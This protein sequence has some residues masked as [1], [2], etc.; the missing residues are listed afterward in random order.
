MKRVE[1][2]RQINF[3]TIGMNID[4]NFNNELVG[5]KIRHIGFAK[6]YTD[7]EQDLL[8]IVFEDDTYIAAQL[9]YD[10]YEHEYRFEGVRIDCPG[11]VDFVRENIH[12]G[13]N[14]KVVLSQKLRML[15]DFGIYEIS[16]EDLVKARKDYDKW[17]R[18]REYAEYLRLKE[19][20]ENNV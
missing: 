5:K 15:I 4:N 20:F 13:D 8:C 3:D 1:T 19:K 11:G 10:P 6:N 7:H 16:D 18:D 14:D 9:A 17:I 2:L 12:F